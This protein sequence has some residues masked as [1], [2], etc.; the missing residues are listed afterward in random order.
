VTT[1]RT[2]AD[3]DNVI[4]TPTPFTTVYAANFEGASPGPWTLT[5]FGL[6]RQWRGESTVYFQSSI[7]GD[8]RASIGAPADDQ[9]VRVRARLDTFASPTGTQE[10]WF[11]LMARQVDSSNY[12]YLSLRSSN[13]LSLRK[14]VDGVPVVLATANY[15]VL[16]ATWYNLRLDAVGDELRAYV[17]GTLRL[18]VRDS[19]H[20]RGRS[21]LVMFKTAADYDDFVA[22][23]P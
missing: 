1:D 2:A 8:A 23:Q 6:W 18:E 10:R 21:G 17:N 7:A 9:V 5:G 16:P 20:E 14:L 11:G 19:T 3:F 13:T 22:Y 15:T 4:V 12:Y